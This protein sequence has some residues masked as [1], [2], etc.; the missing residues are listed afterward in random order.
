MP[1]RSVRQFVFDAMLL[2]DDFRRLRNDGIDID[3]PS[4]A[5][6]IERASESDFSPRILASASK[7][8]SV[9]VL[10]F[11]L[12][13]S[14]RELIAD[15][16]RERKGANWWDSVPASV[17]KKV[18]ELRSKEKS[19]RYHTERSTELLGYTFFGNLAQT[20]I[21]N[22]DE[23]SDLFPDQAWVTSRFNDLEL[24]RNI[25]MHTGILPEFEIDRVESIAR[26]WLRQV[27]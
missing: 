24:S 26:D 6:L 18:A 3:L 22:W 19:N 13:N 4:E 5:K 21:A 23:F 8:A 17:R 16:L 1:E 12:E 7:M 9:Y 14:A 15:R 25:V 20:I 2:Q 10:V 11:A 27:G